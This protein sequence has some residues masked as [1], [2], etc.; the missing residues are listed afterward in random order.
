MHH[1]ALSEQPEEAACYGRDS[2]HAPQR[3]SLRESRTPPFRCEQH[4]VHHHRRPGSLAQSWSASV[5]GTAGTQTNNS[6]I[7]MGSRG[8]KRKECGTAELQTRG[9]CLSVGNY[10]D[11]YRVSQCAELQGCKDTVAVHCLSQWSPRRD[12]WQH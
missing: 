12:S 2:G 10:R 6:F 3:T 11:T 5:R 9:G 8:V 7:A 1:G 4:P